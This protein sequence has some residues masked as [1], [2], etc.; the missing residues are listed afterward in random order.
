MAGQ[1]ITVP[2][3]DYS[4][5][6]YPDILK[7]VTQYR[8]QN[9]PEVTDENQYEPY[10][11]LERAYS[12]VGHYNNVL[13]D[14]V[15]NESLLPT[16]KLLESVRN[17]LKK[18]DYHLSQA[19][20]ASTNV[21]YELSK[22]FTSTVNF[23]PQYSQSATEETTEQAQIIYEANDDHTIDRTDQL[24]YVFAFNAAFI[25]VV[26]NTWDAGDY[27]K[28]NT[29][30]FLYG[31]AFVAGATK[32]ETAANI[33]EAI[34]TSTD[35]AIAGKIMALVDG[36]QVDLINIDDTTEIILVEVDG[37]TNN[38]EVGSG[39]YSTN[40]AGTAN[41]DGVFFSPWTAPKKGD[42]LYIAH[43]HI[44]HDKIS[45]ELNAAAAGITGVW[46][47]YDGELEDESPTSIQ[48]LGS[49]LKLD[50]SSL[51]PSGT[52]Y[53]G[54]VVRIKLQEN[55]AYEYAISYYDSGVN[56][57]DTTGLLGQVTPST[58]NSDYVIGSTWQPL[59]DVVD[60]TANFTQDGDIA[61]TLPETLTQ[62]WERR[63]VNSLYSG[64][65]LRYRVVSVSTPTSPTV[66]ILRIDQGAQYIK[67][68]VT[69]G[70]FRSE[71]PL[72]SSDASA[73]QEFVLT[74]AP[75][76]PGSL[77]VEVNEGT[78][79][80]S[81][82]QRDNFLSSNASSR[83][84][85]IDI[86]ADDTVTIKFGDGTRGKIPALGVDN[87]RAFYRTGA[88]VNGNVGAETITVNK[89]GISFVNRIFNPRQASGW[90]IKEGSTPEDL[91]R[92][93][94]EGPA[95]IRVLDRGITPTDFEYLAENY[96]T[97]A[98]SKLVSRAKAIEET[99]GIKTIELICVSQGGVQLSAAERTD[100]QDYF[101]GNKVRGIE[102][103]GLANHEVTAVNYTKN[104]IDVTC[105]VVGGNKTE[106]ENAIQ[107]FLNP[108][109]KYED[110]TTHR[111]E[112]ST[113]QE[114]IYVR[115]ALLYAIINE[116]DPQNIKN[117]IITSPSADVPL[118]LRELPF[119]GVINVS[120]S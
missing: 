32:A 112:F 29:V 120:V 1:V 67:V 80:T 115:V 63:T 114:T 41:T 77:V 50:L 91:A 46:E 100:I 101:N 15:A 79:F 69:Q 106:I 104:V 117:I 13:L 72:G 18:I 39:E 119:P 62:T 70:Q 64:Y 6:Y 22:V 58:E 76:I 11:Q 86:A 94:I 4:G 10:I 75:L 48:N 89:A 81:W 24:S 60:G 14:V 51:L 95:S 36:E 56:Y 12:L 92:V 9:A 35:D 47:Y 28:I 99:F 34:N 97:D 93:K 78:G 21:I 68:G 43:K 82:S 2:T 17:H 5:I 110:G 26:D 111:W 38:M 109:A 116:V 19:T 44:Q 96:T 73:N 7:M 65:F 8:R 87:I 61:F 98:G 84:Y 42:T 85:T 20:P 53:S 118:A 52:D 25:T 108:E 103:K 49:N 66:N 113:A 107:N 27:F 55:S 45:L 83:D 102:G 105:S 71:D 57:A 31:A 37:A 59:S 54:T 23:I 30:T 74:F 88:E 3:I 16:A 33:A 90:V 40:H